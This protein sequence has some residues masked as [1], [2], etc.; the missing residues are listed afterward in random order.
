MSTT[1]PQWSAPSS[2]AEIEP[3]A[4]VDTKYLVTRPIARGGVADVFE[5]EHLVTS[6]TVALK[7]LRRNTVDVVSAQRRLLQE[8]R[9]L[10]ALRHPN[11]VTIHD[12]GRCARFGP[13]LVL[14]RIDGR[15]LEDLLAV[16]RTLAVGQVVALVTELAAALDHVHERGFVHRDVKPGNVL[17][18]AR[19]GGH[20]VVK[21]V[22]FGIATRT[23]P[24]VASTEKITRQGE[25]LGTVEYM[26]PEQLVYGT[27]GTPQSDVYALG[28][29]LYESLSGRVPFPGEA[30]QIIARMAAGTRPAPVDAERPEIPRALAAAVHRAMSLDPER[31]FASALEL[32]QACASAVEGMSPLRLLSGP[33]EGTSR[34]RFRRAPYVAPVR[35]LMAGVTVDGRTVDIS[36]GGALILGDVPCAADRPVRIRLP[37]PTSGRVTELEATTRWVKDHRTQRAFGVEFDALPQEVRDEISGYVQHMAP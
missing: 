36:E 3:G 1:S 17:V 5:A 30:P 29:V 21:V 27:S 22:D 31:R 4:S 26:A 10:G 13:Y 9:I 32:A 18:G 19:G 2:N 11:V 34:R 14:E 12:A 8:A 28:V 6:A 23:W 37:L 25:L 7:V 35:V 20:E 24:S 33:L 15:S 16:R